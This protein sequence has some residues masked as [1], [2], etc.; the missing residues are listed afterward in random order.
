MNKLC[1]TCTC[2]EVV[3]RI[4]LQVGHVSPNISSFLGSISSRRKETGNA[5]SIS[6]IA[7]DVIQ[8]GINQHF[9]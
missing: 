6:G 4:V 3:Y 1:F 7:Q 9:S 8:G 2:Q 5:P